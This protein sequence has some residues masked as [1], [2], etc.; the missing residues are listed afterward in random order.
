VL[1][2]A[3]RPTAM[4]CL[5]D[6][7]AYGCYLAAHRLQLAVPEDLSVLGYDD[8]EMAELVMPGLTTFSWEDA[9]IVHSAVAQLV[10]A[11]E[12]SGRGRPRTFRP[13][14]KQRGSTA[15]PMGPLSPR[16]PEVAAPRRS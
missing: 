16:H 14:L 9:A 4:F 15:R 2:S 3:D 1:A 6:S 7:M 12:L 13:Q 5:S 8:H 11:I 10:R